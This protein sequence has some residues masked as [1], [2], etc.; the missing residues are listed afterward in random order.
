MSADPTQRQSPSGSLERKLVGRET[1]L[2][3][4]QRWLDQALSGQRQVVFVTGEPGIGKTTLIDVFLERVRG[5]PEVHI[6]H[7]QCIEQYGAGEAYLPL[8]E[9]AHRLCRGPGGERMIEELK[10][11]APTWLAQLSGLI[12]QHE[13]ELLQQRV[14][15]T[16]RERMLREMAETAELFT[17]RRGLVL[18]LEDLQ[19]SDTA[20]LEWLAYTARRREPAKLLI[21]G[22]YRPADVLMSGHPLKGVVQELRAGG[23]GEELPLAPLAETAVHDYLASR[24]ASMDISPELL[25]AIHRRTGGH[26]LFLMHI[27]DYLCEHGAIVADGERLTLTS[28]LRTIENEVPESLRQL[29][30]KQIERLD[31]DA[32]RA[33]EVAS[34]VGVEFAVALVA[35][36]LQQPS[37]SIEEVCERLARKGQFIAA[38]GIEEWPDGTLSGRYGFM[39]TLY[40]NVLSGRIAAARRVRL[41]RLIATRKE[42]AYGDRVGEITSELAVRF[43]GGRDMQRAVH[44]L[45]RAAANAIRR[46][47]Y[48][49]AINHLTKGVVLLETLPDTPERAQQEVGLQ[50]ALSGTREQ[51]EGR[52]QK[53]KTAHHLSV[54]VH[55]SAEAHSPSSP[56]FFTLSTQP[57]TPNPQPPAP[58]IF[59]REGE[60]WTLAFGGVV[61]RLRENRGMR[62]LALLLQHPNEELHALRIVADDVLPDAAQPGTVLRGSVPEVVATEENPQAGFSDAGELLDPQARA[63]YTQR[64]ADLQAELAEA[65]AYND[66]DRTDR[67]Q[68]EIAFLTQELSQAVGLGGRVRKAAAATE[69]AHVNVTK[70]MK[71]AI[72][73]I[74]KSHP[75]LGH[76]LRQTIR[77]GTCCSYTSDPRS[78]ISW[79]T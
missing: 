77:T 72:N 32:Q 60:Y 75:A 6:A 53:R 49:E 37:E 78:P 12:D 68:E 2:A 59:Q 79:Q 18:V 73:K 34:V 7:G 70:A 48:R 71:S 10:Q 13:S 55:R 65:Q 15:G 76:H 62:Y 74:S 64:L 19:W 33:L 40:Q 11:Y 38:R 20:T 31:E 35:V 46:H 43:E 24:F 52:E 44:C 25:R 29:I 26:P 63:A 23:Q 27:V 57:P 41:H 1:E 14:Q 56:Q 5:H 30:E 45:E 21:I 16:S 4:L 22:T 36:G 50:T 51:V 47:A 9:A 58:S 66:S 42:E 69:R 67:L 3:Q 61:C 28:D 17:A 54:G 8:L 39:H